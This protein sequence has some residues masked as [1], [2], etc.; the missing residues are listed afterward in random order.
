MTDTGMGRLRKYAAQPEQDTAG[1]R[2]T[3]RVNA[4]SKTD[5]EQDLLAIGEG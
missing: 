1:I 5:M 3:I 4:Y 2:M